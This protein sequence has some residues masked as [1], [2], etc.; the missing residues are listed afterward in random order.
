MVLEGGV[1]LNEILEKDKLI[2]VSKNKQ[3]KIKYKQNHGY[4][5]Q[6]PGCQKG[7]VEE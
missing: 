5:E 2:C 3:N 7:G 1:I 4:R 6:M